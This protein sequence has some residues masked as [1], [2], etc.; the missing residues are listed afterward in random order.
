MNNRIFVALLLAAVL[1]LPALAQQTSSTPQDQ[2]AASQPAATGSTT[3]DQPAASQP[4]QAAPAD[5]S[6]PAAQTAGASGKQPLRILARGIPSNEV[7]LSV[8]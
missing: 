4:A 3:Q 7:N 2:P 1:A 8:R 5:Q 6:A